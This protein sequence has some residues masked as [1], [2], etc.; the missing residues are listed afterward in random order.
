[1]EDRLNDRVLPVNKSAG[2]STYD[3]I[4]RLKRLIHLD[5]IGH[6]G[7]L[8]PP[9]TGLI[10][11]LTGE[12][13]KLSN[14]LMDLPK[15]YVADIKLGESTDTQDATGKVVRT[16]TWEHITEGD[17]ASV[18]PGFWGKRMQIPPMFSALKHKGKPLYTLAR[19]G[20]NI[21]RSPR[22]TNTYEI[23][24]VSCSMPVFR[25]EVFCSRGLYIRMLAEEIGEA[26]GVPAHLASL[27]RTEIGHFDLDSAVP[28]DAFGALI[29]KG[30]AGYSLSDA[31]KHLPSLTLSAEQVHG[32][33]HGVVPRMGSS[34]PPRGTFVRLIRPDG[35]LGAIGEV[36]RT[37]LLQIKRVFRDRGLEEGGRAPERP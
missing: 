18:L 15:R 31:V 22:E 20:R 23:E 5:K 7:T 34:L 1:M 30:E 9:A 32:L 17:V 10:L 26:L 16:D 6:S 2:V 25:I 13:T 21:E 24:L 35:G 28:D 4:R 8:D 12:A 29:E 27:V 3:C 36:G 11:L 14:Y 33:M 37:G 19:M